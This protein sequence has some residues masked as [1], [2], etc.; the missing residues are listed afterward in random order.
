MDVII[1]PVYGCELNNLF[2]DVINAKS[3]EQ[4]VH[5]PTRNKNILALRLV[6]D[7]SESLTM[8]QFYLVSMPRVLPVTTLVII[9]IC[10][11][12]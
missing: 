7:V 6:V 11:K 2:L 8:M 4:F 10:T 5:K 1:Y 3:L 9:P 12:N